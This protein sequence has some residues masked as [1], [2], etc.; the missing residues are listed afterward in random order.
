MRCQM[1]AELPF[2]SAMDRWIIFNCGV[3]EI[4]ETDLRLSQQSWESKFNT[5][6]HNSQSET[7]EDRLS[8]LVKNAYIDVAINEGKAVRLSQAGVST[9]ISIANPDF[10]KAYEWTCSESKVNGFD[11]EISVSAK[12]IKTVLE[13][14]FSTCNE[15]F[16]GLVAIDSLTIS[17][18]VPFS[19][20]YWHRD[21]GVRLT[22]V[23][24]NV[25]STM[26]KIEK[27]NRYCKWNRSWF[28][29]PLSR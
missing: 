15:G 23:A 14:L 26:E 11:Y 1:N 19:A 29:D 5:K 9:W 18:D 28:R 3:C 7:I 13:V 8:I 27:F 16:F 20:A 12:T 6:W 10:E 22:F 2:L 24:A 21:I 17:P 25:P 4:T